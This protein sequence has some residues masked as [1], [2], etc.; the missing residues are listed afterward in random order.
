[1][2]N[3]P[4]KII[5][6]HDAA[7]RRGPSFDIT[8]SYHKEQQYPVSRLGFYV[9]YHYFIEKDGSLRQA[10]ED[11]EIGAHTIGQNDKSIGVCLAGNFDI[12]LPTTAQVKTLGKLL[13][14]LTKQYGIPDTEVYP[15][16]KFAQKACYG[17]KLHDLWAREVL[18]DARG[19]NSVAM[20]E[21]PKSTVQGV[22]KQLQDLL[23]KLS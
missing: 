23:P 5:V 18:A 21:T 15:H 13:L 6:H 19:G 1:M 22:I 9:G 10:R 20:G 11:N 4:K 2:L 3:T 16:R 8:N 12:E 7:A 14:T 17:G